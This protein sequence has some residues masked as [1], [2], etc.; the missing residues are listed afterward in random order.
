VTFIFLSI[1]HLLLH[2]FKSAGRW[3]GRTLDYQDAR[4]SKDILEVQQGCRQLQGRMYQIQQ[5]R[6]Q[7]PGFDQHQRTLE[8]AVT[9]STA[10]KNR[11]QQDPQQQQST[12][13]NKVASNGRDAS[14]RRT[15]S[16]RRDST[17]L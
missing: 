9:I 16:I 5:G 15:A 11:Y 6:L 13:N 3:H 1:S 8:N 4:N 14:S 10:A 17:L 2:N 12:F 7:Q